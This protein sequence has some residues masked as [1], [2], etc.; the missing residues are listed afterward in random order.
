MT[1][2]VAEKEKKVWVD[3]LMK[4]T[5]EVANSLREFLLEG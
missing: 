4:A 1:Q 2:L 5:E 3:L